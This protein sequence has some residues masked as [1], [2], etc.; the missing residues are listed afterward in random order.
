M[1]HLTK[2]SIIH[3]KRF[4]LRL[5]PMQRRQR[6]TELCMIR[7]PVLQIF[8]AGFPSNSL[9]RNHD[10]SPYKQWL[11]TCLQALNILWR[12][13]DW[14]V[15]GDITF[16]V[17]TDIYVSSLI[18]V[19]ILYPDILKCSLNLR[20]NPISQSLAFPGFKM[21]VINVPTVF[22]HSHSLNSNTKP[23]LTKISII[24]INTIWILN[25]C[26]IFVMFHLLKVLNCLTLQKFWYSKCSDI[27][28]RVKLRDIP[29]LRKNSCEGIKL[30]EEWYSP[31]I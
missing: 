14:T 10:P 8:C 21:I 26:E 11:Q 16:L 28:C 22:N 12:I 23:Y 1:I 7:N 29:F 31:P 13:Y 5:L 18:S 4:C 15:I 24:T 27:Q 6:D 17:I 3:S 20:Y 25:K 9:R 30:G 2:S 19:Q